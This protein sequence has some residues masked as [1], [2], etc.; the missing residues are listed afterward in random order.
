MKIDLVANSGN[1]NQMYLQKKQLLSLTLEEKIKESLNRIKEWYFNNNGKVYVAFSGGK[2]STVL[3]HLARSIFPNIKAVFNDT[4]LEYPDIRN[5]A[6]SQKNVI[7]L[8][9]RYNFKEVLEKYGYPI[10]SKEQSQFIYQYRNAKSEKTKM[11]RLYG[12]DTTK[13][14]ISKKWRFLIDAPFKISDK[15][16]DIMKKNPSKQYEKETGEKAMIGKT[17]AESSSRTIEF[18]TKPCLRYDKKRPIA[19]PIMFWNEQD[20][21]LYLSKYNVPYCDIYKKGFK[22]TGC[23]FCAFGAQCKGDNRFY[24]MEKHYPKIYDYCMNKL[25]MKQVLD[26]IKIN[27]KE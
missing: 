3:L 6:L 20:I 13:H 11:T 23:M 10:I 22:R 14:K 25:K 4:G 17:Y 2:D 1:D 9:P 19:L 26:F 7:S 15:C 12:S 21:W 5:F 8:K 27:Q 24:L 16:C 18:F